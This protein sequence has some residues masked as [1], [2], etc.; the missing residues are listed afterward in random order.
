MQLDDVFLAKFAEFGPDGLFTVVG[1]GVDRINVGAF[2]WSWGFLYL[3]ARVRLTTE[4]AQ[5]QHL[6]NVERETPN[7]NIEPVTAES[8]MEPLSPTAEIGPDGRVGLTFIVYLVNLFF[9]EAGVYKYRFKIDG[10][11]IG[12]AELLVA[13]PPQG[14]QVQ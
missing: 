12:V 8:P 1:G 3:I 7:G 2:P 9:A 10:Q 13:G 14:E 6:T 5:A 11:E 4:E